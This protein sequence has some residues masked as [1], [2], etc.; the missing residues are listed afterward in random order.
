MPR[1]F[2]LWIAAELLSVSLNSLPFYSPICDHFLEMNMAI[3]DFA[4]N[5]F[6]V[7]TLV[8][9]IVY[10]SPRHKYHESQK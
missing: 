3:F 10:R 7:E 1:N 9:F 4:L 8:W 6:A 5:D 2:D